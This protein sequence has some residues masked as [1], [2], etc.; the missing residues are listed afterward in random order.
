MSNFQKDALVV[1]I[2]TV[3]PSWSS[4]DQKTQDYLSQREKKY[5]PNFSQDQ[6]SQRAQETLFLAPGMSRVICIGMYRTDKVGGVLLRE[7][8]NDSIQKSTDNNYVAVCGDETSLRENFWQ[9]V[10]MAKEDGLR[11]VTFYGEH[12]DIPVLLMRSALLGVTPTVGLYTSKFPKTHTFHLD[13]D[14]VLTSRGATKHYSLDYWC[15]QFNI[16]SPK[17]HG[18]TGADVQNAYKQG[19]IMD[20]GDYCM[21]DVL[22]TSELYLKLRNTLLPTFFE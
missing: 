15:R 22:A 14:Q 9:R 3:T 4:I 2:E 16:S 1:D 13:L 11:F 21:R 18:M 10:K 19:R 20:I 5:N 8:V 7:G 12:Y 17:D 6:A